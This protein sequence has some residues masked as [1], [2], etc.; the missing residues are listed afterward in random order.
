MSKWYNGGGADN[1]IV[2]F[3][4]VRL[5]FSPVVKLPPEGMAVN[6]SVAVLSFARVEVSAIRLSP[7][8]SLA[9]KL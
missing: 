3:S 4:K 8:F 6:E 1:D 2:L 5:A 7:S 9:T